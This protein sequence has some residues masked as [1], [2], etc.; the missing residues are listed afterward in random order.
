MVPFASYHLGDYHPVVGSC[1]DS[2]DLAAEHN[3][4][5]MCIGQ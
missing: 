1:A 5:S 2:I 4:A 3:A